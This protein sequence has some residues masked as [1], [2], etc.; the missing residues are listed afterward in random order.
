[1]LEVELGW[2]KHSLSSC[3]RLIS[4]ELMSLMRSVQA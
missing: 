2:Q 4:S 1:M 3:A